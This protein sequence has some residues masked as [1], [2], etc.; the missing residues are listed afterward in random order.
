MIVA[1]S[2]TLILLGIGMRLLYD[3]VRQ[4]YII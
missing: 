3:M 2:F 1:V 4:E